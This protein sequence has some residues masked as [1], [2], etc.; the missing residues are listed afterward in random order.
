MLCNTLKINNNNLYINSCYIQSMTTISPSEAILAQL[1]ASGGVTT[2]RVLKAAVPGIS[3][4]TFSRLID[5]LRGQL[6][7]LG[8]K[9]A[10]RYGLLRSVRGRGSRFP[11]YEVDEHGNISSVGALIALWG[12]K[13]W[14]EPEGGEAGTLYDDIPFF[15]D[16]MRPQ[17]FL[18]R[19]F[20]SRFPDLDLPARVADWNQDQVM[21]ALLN[22]GEDGPGNL[23]IGDI[24]LQRLLAG[25]GEEHPLMLEE[26]GAAFDV[27]A[28]AALGGHPPSSSAGGDQLKFTAL[29]ARPEQPQRAIVK[30][31]PLLSTPAG[32]R[33]ADLLVCELIAL[34]VA[35]AGGI[36][37]SRAEVV[38]T[39]QRAY[40]QVDRFDR[41]G[42]RGRLGMISLG[43]LD[44][45]LFGERNTTYIEA[46]GRLRNAHIL[47]DEECDQLRWI[48]VFGDLIANTDMHYGNVSLFSNLK[49]DYRLAPLYDTLPML[50]A[51][52]A[53]EV[54]ERE[55]M[56][57]I[58]G[59]AAAAQ[60]KSASNAA[61]IFWRTVGEDARVSAEF[62]AI[63]AENCAKVAAVAEKLAAFMP[64][65]RPS[66]RVRP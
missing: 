11:V 13:Y 60:W 43:A 46:A 19:S 3:Q 37:A 48:G 9:R 12:G 18:G 63:A 58:P 25:Q 23:L 22:R 45:Q 20:S 33:W 49:G 27:L 2:G 15:I 26:R 16:D 44:D 53:D 40:L 42:L 28:D 51:P 6:A 55:F 21:V 31:S 36:A 4:P 14:F 50:Y 56:P 66:T 35:R 24:S 38:L 10:A 64:P 34:Q 62:R 54:R 57:A 30:F 41:V 61:V 1:R 39:G 29:L 32:R 8:R 5:G 65:A 17:G 7:V 52:V 47:G 59:T